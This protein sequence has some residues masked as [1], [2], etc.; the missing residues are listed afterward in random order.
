[1]ITKLGLRGLYLELRDA[2]FPLKPAIFQTSNL[3]FEPDYDYE[4]LRPIQALRRTRSVSI[5]QIYKIYNISE[6]I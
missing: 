5:P 6:G 1:M 2:Q 3:T 4:T